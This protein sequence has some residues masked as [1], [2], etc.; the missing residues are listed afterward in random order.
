MSP[1][2]KRSSPEDSDGQK[3]GIDRDLDGLVAP[4]PRARAAALDRLWGR[5]CNQGSVVPESEAAVV[6]LL[7]LAG[8]SGVPERHTIL[9]LLI[10]IA[11]GDH[12]NFLDGSLAPTR[13]RGT[14]RPRGALRSLEQ[15]CFEAVESRAAAI[16][17][18]LADRDARVRGAA[19]FAL[20]WLGDPR[21]ASSSAIASRGAVERD[22]EA[23][24]S[25]LIAG[26]HLGARA[27]RPLLESLVA[28]VR[29]TPLLRA[30]AAIGLVYLDGKRA[31]EA[32]RDVLARASTARAFRRTTLSWN[33]GDLAGHAAA[34]LAT[35]PIRAAGLPD[36][37][38]RLR[39][40]GYLDGD[41]AAGELV[42]K[43]FAG[44][45]RKTAANLTDK[46][47]A[48]LEAIV[49]AGLLRGSG[50]VDHWLRLR[51]LPG[52]EELPRFI[53]VEAG[54]HRELRRR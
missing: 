8:A 19:A 4:T 37:V 39:S 38:A 49:R 53:G 11:V 14:S 5:L 25:M 30:A 16:R 36:A 50:H 33:G 34:V 22:V 17:V 51:G 43:V 6:P 28:D 3:P 41:R 18:L 40:L 26:G 27:Q 35:I 2:V 23:R 54:V 47:R 20:A 1:R 12:T 29:T 10:G 45:G 32:V 15:R 24:A 13:R 52:I 44:R 7:R 21:T 42:K 31:P 46:Q 48:L 9:E